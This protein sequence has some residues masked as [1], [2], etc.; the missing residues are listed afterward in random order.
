MHQNV[1]VWI[2]DIP[3]SFS[4]NIAN[5]IALFVVGVLLDVIKFNPNESYQARPTQTGI[6]IILFLGALLSLISSFLVF[7]KYKLKQKHFENDIVT[8]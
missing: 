2:L 5:A 1:S 3:H 6:A 7:S 8:D 4:Y